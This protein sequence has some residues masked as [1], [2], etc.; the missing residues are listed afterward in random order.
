VRS[1]FNLLA[2]MYEGSNIFAC[3]E[4]GL[5]VLMQGQAHG[6]RVNVVM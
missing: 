1:S 3:D 2:C 6:G 4:R 5:R